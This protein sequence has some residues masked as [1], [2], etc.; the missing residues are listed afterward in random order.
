MGHHLS[1]LFSGFVPLPLVGAAV[2]FF[3]MVCGRSVRQLECDAAHGFIVYEVKSA[4]FTNIP[5][6]DRST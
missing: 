6:L 3:Y 2:N 4:K 5:F 1:P